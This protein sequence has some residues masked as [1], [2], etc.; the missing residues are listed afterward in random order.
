M[1]GF[2]LLSDLFIGYAAFQ[3]H[4]LKESSAVS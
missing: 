2:L 4:A 1:L 3:K